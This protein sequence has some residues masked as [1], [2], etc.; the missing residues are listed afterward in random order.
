MAT[1]RMKKGSV[2]AD[3]FDSPETI[4]NA[5]LEGYSLCDEKPI[6]TVVEEAI[7]DALKV[8]NKAESQTDEQKIVHKKTSK[9]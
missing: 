7:V 9:K 6:D 2:Y 4:R 3:V 1:V 5:Q 8:E